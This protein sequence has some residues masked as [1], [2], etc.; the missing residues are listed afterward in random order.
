MKT[1]IAS[2][3]SI[4]IAIMVSMLAL[5]AC[6]GAAG[7]GKPASAPA[8]ASQYQAIAGYC[9]IKAPA[10]AGAPDGWS[11]TTTT[12]DRLMYSASSIISAAGS[13]EAFD[14]GISLKINISDY[15]GGDGPQVGRGATRPEWV[16]GAVIPTAFAAQSVACVVHL[17]KLRNVYTTAQG[18]TTYWHGSLPMAQLP[19]HVI[20][21]FEFVSNFAPKAGALFFVLDKVGFGNLQA[22]SLCYLAPQKTQWE[23]AAASLVD[24]GANWEVRAT[25]MRPGAYVLVSTSRR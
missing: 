10:S 3:L 21:G 2:F 15:R 8:D 18:W 16:M 1:T 25:G 11:V 6:G 13:S 22:P 7:G 20:D 23:C 19:G 17:S 5:S 14:D 4:S 9:G 24:A 12:L